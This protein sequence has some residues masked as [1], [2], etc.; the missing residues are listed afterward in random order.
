MDKDTRW[1]LL[2]PSGDKIACMTNVIY[3]ELKRRYMDINYLREQAI[4]TPT[5]DIADV[6]NNYIVSSVPE[7]ENNI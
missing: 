1:T 7:D 3:P 2:K 6:I 4:L 5:N